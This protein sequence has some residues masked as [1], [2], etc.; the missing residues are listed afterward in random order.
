MGALFTIILELLGVI[1]KNPIFQKIAIF[2]FFFTFVGF[3][4][5]FFVNKFVPLLSNYS[6]IFILASY[7]GFFNALQVFLNFLVTGFIVKQILAFIRS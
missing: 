1:A 3:A 7:L 2:S 4:V 6:Q 5:D